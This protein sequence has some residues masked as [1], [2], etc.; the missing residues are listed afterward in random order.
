M[1]AARMSSVYNICFRVIIAPGKF[2][3]PFPG[4]ILIF[5]VYGITG[6]VL[7]TCNAVRCGQRRVMAGKG[8]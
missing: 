6:Y 2:G 5:D 7:L 1:Q 4:R 8:L 3:N